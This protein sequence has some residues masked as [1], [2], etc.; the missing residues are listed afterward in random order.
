VRPY[1]AA[2]HTT[3]GRMQWITGERYKTGPDSRPYS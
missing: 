2:V 3:T 1:A